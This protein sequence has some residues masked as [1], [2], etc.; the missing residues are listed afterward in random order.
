MPARQTWSLDEFHGGIDLRDGQFSANQTRFRELENVWIDKGKKIRRR[1]PCLQAS[2]ELDEGC[3]GL[4]SVD[5]QFFTFAPDGLGGTHTGDLASLV[6]TLHFTIPNY[7]YADEWTLLAAGVFNGHAAAW[8]LHAYESAEYP[9]VA[10]LHVWD[11]LLYAPT[12]VQDPYLPGSFSPSIADL[13]DQ[14]YDATFHPVMGQ[15]AT[16]LWT[17]TLRGNA[18][19]SRTADARIWNQRTKDSLLEDGEYWCYIVPEG[20]GVLRH[21]IVPRDAEWLYHDSSRPKTWA[22]YV[23]EYN[24]DGE[25]IPMEEVYATPTAAFTWQPASVASRFSG[26]WNEIRVSVMWGRS[27]AGLIRLRLV[28]GATSVVVPNNPTVEYVAGSGSAWKLRIGPTKY[29]HR[30]QDSVEVEGYDTADLVD[31]KTYLL[32]V[33]ADETDHPALFNQTDSSYYLPNGWGNEHRKWFKQIVT[34]AASSGTT[35]LET[36][37]TP[38]A[39]ARYFG[40]KTEVSVSLLLASTT[41]VGSVIVVSSV[42]YIVSDKVGGILTVTDMTGADGDYTANLNAL[43]TVDRTNEPV[44]TDYAY[45]FDADTESEWYTDR[46]IEYVDQAGAEDALSIATSSHDNTGGI[47]TSI[48]AVRQRMLIT[49]SGSMQLWAIDQDTNRTQHLDTLSFGTGDQLAPQPVPW[50][51]SLALPVV[52]GI[53]AI[54]VVGANTDNLQDLNIGEPIEPMPALSVSAAGFWPWYG[55]LVFAGTTDA[56]AELRVLDYSRESKITAW[57]RWSF[58]GIDSVDADTLIPLGSDLWFRS[59]RSVFHI[60]AAATVFR[61]FGDDEGDAYV[62]S[63]YFHFNDMGKPGSGKRIVGMDI[64]QDGTSSVSFR[65]P[66]YGAD[67]AGE[68][69]GPDVEGPQ[70]EGITYG[71][72]RIPLSMSATAIAPRITT[73]DEA[74]WRLQRL[75][76]DFLL[77]RR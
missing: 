24:Q 60:D 63:A 45:A 14:R 2:G 47:I 19:C 39:Y 21:F 50:Y 32:A 25:W 1:P 11:G 20:S 76:L 49:Y 33:T 53:R 68:G 72:T 7:A 57:S 34:I 13:T 36:S 70:I 67:F 41:I 69:A 23:L 48:S 54:S 74:G 30:G 56:G 71:L 66:P 5:G 15:G 61:D 40:G 28:A 29:Q 64:V 8:I 65:L 12:F 4:I 18:N 44:I 6:E 37:W 22:Y 52:N 43:K 77:L 26:G 9:A 38:N 59:G 55:Q 16:K 35:V 42:K 3:Q 51:G 73:Q 58:D 10:M 62:S 27:S 46:V 17:G 31:G 75:S